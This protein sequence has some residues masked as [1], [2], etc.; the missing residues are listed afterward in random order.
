MV[1]KLIKKQRIITFTAKLQE[2]KIIVCKSCNYFNS[3][4][5]NEGVE[6]FKRDT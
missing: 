1:M 6:L 5:K 3:F 4:P 2:T